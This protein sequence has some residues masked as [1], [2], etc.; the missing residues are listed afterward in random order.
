VHEL[1]HL[2]DDHFAGAKMLPP[3]EDYIREL[4]TQALA[5]QNDIALDRVLPQLQA[6][7]REYILETRISAVQVIPRTFP[8]DKKVA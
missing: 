4:C 5:A 7:I 1:L 3:L 8:P 2:S 6:A